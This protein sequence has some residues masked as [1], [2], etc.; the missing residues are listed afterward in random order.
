MEEASARMKARLGVMLRWFHDFCESQGLRYYALGGTMLGAARHQNFIPWD[1]DV[2]IGMPRKDYLR[3]WQ[4]LAQNPHPQYC[5]ETPFSENGDFCYAFSKLY[6]TETTLIENTRSRICRGVYLDIFPLDGAGASREEAEIFQ[7]PIRW[8]TN[9]LLA[10]TTG[11]RRGRSPGKNAAVLLLRSVPQRLLQKPLQRSL[12]R[13]CARKD[14]D[15]CM[16]VGNLTGNYGPRELMPRS[17]FGEPT[18]YP[19]GDFWVYGPEQFDAY[20]T[21][22]YG[23]WR[24]LPPADKQKSHHDFLLV[25][26]EHGYRCKC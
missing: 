17:Y 25:D 11:L 13:L 12:H 5:L 22:L 19:F 15:G 20:L 21:H 14:F 18:R 1:D 7:K 16:W 23:Q 2:D 9:L 26:L 10:L 8:R 24:I 6:D 4:L 3:L